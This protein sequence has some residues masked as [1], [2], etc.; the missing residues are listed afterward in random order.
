MKVTWLVQDVVFFLTGTLR[1]AVIL[2]VPYIAFCALLRLFG[3]TL[4]KTAW[5]G[6]WVAVA[7]AAGMN[8]A[9]WVWGEEVEGPID[10]DEE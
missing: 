10:P 9:L 7:F 8:A 4:L 3:V 5:S 6:I 1:T 2:I